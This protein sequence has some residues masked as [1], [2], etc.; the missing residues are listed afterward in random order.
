M[1]DGAT[2][3]ITRQLLA[4]DYDAATF[5]V[6]CAIVATVN[7]FMGDPAIVKFS[8]I[9]AGDSCQY[10]ITADTTGWGGSG[11]DLF[12]TETLTCNTAGDEITIEMAADLGGEM[13]LHSVS[14]W[15]RSY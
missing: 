12:A 11:P 9:G 14:I 1:H 10:N 2:L 5:D 15:D 6:T 8:S 13:I 4:S 7:T 3:K